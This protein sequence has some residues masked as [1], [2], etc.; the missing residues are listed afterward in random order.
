MSIQLERGTLRDRVVRFCEETDNSDSGPLKDI[1]NVYWMEPLR[2]TIY[3]RNFT[4]IKS[5]GS[6]T[7][8]VVGTNEYDEVDEMIVIL[9]DKGDAPRQLCQQEDAIMMDIEGMPVAIDAFAPG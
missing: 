6:N 9:N 8:C 7:L 5:D 3:S 2:A 1:T 4:G